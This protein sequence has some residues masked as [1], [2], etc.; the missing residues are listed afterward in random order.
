[1]SSTIGGAS[2]LQFYPTDIIETFNMFSFITPIRITDG[3]KN[4]IKKVLGSD[5]TS[6]YR[7]VFTEYADANITGVNFDTYLYLYLIKTHRMNLIKENFKLALTSGKEGKLVI[8]DL[9]A[10]EGEWL[11]TF[12]FFGDTSKIHLIANEIEEGRYNKIKQDDLIDECYHGSFEELNLPKNSISL[13]LFNPPYGGSDGIRNTTRY[14]NMMLER[15]L[16]YN[17]E[18]N[19]GQIIMVLRG[20]DIM[21]ISEELITNFSINFSTMYRVDSDEFSKYK[22]FVVYAKLRKKSLD[23]TQ[24]GQLAMF[25]DEIDKL[26]TII[27]EEKPMDISD[28]RFMYYNRPSCIDYETIK[29]N[30]KF[31]QSESKYT[32]DENNKNWKWI[33][34]ITELKEHGQDKLVIPKPPKTGELALI[35]A[36]GYINGNIEKENGSAKHIVIGGVK[37]LTRTEIRKETGKDGE[38]VEKQVTTKFTKPYL[39]LLINNKGKIEIKEL[40]SG[41]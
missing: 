35:M 23:L 18:K 1:M 8:A 15:E 17:G 28:T 3:G 37:N 12:K 31:I 2:K 40:G 39:N 5:E 34:D 41:E 21:D 27:S 13:M 36:S 32:S 11:K 14:F 16:L 29:E 9:F 38:I 19:Q 20:D 33:K 7:K 24:Q 6:E 22:Q 25:Q 30:F 10:G 4:N 26:K